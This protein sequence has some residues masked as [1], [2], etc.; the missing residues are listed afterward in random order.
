MAEN[1]GHFHAD[2]NS[3]I[4]KNYLD[5]LDDIVLKGLFNCVHCSLQYFLQNLDKDKVDLPPLMEIKL[6][7]QAPEVIFCPS[8]ES[9]ASNG[10]CHL[11]EE[12]LEDMFYVSSLVPRVAAHKCADN[13]LGDVEE[14]SELFDMREDVVSRVSAAIDKAVEHRNSFDTYAYLWVDDRQEFMKQFLLYGHVLTAEEIEQAGEEGVPETPP[15]LVQF[16]DQVDGFEKIYNEL[17]QLNVSLQQNI[18]CL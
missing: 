3:D 1:R 5:Y 10:F 6:E 7:L 18:I 17:S 9:E 11:V 15:S 16:K 13:Y 8:L 12:L 2:E 14:M 4:W